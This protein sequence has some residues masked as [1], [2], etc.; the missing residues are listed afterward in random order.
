MR[1]L[2]KHLTTPFAFAVAFLLAGAPSAPVTD[3]LPTIG[4]CAWA[5]GP[6][7]TGSAGGDSNAPGGGCNYYDIEADSWGFLRQTFGLAEYNVSYDGGCVDCDD[8]AE[9]QEM[10]AGAAIAMGVGV[11]ASS[12]FPPMAALFFAGATGNA[13]QA[14]YYGR[15]RRL[16]GC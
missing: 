10:H 3:V 12:A 9:A 7:Y 11:W 13:V 2:V 15:I 4:G 5:T 16:S 6:G 8:L 1:Y 14:W